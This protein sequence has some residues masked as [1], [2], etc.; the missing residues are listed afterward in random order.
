MTA[1]E[2]DPTV[3]EVAQ[4]I[5]SRLPNSQTGSERRISDALV[6]A[7]AP[8]FYALQRRIGGVEERLDQRIGGLEERLDGRIDSLEAKVDR[9]GAHMI[10]RLGD[11]DAKL[12]DMD[13]RLGDLDAKLGD[14]DAKLDRLLNRVE[15][16]QAPGG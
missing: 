6:D 12:G 15:D 5:R 13:A 7:F 8:E 2:P 14:M 10:D 3:R 16:G 11:M 4:R 9:L 1:P